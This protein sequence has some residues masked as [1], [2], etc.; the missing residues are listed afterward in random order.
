MSEQFRRNIIFSSLSVM[1]LDGAA[2][3]TELCHS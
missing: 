3:I 1:Y 2:S